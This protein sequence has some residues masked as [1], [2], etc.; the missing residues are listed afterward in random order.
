MSCERER[1]VL[2]CSVIGWNLGGE[3]A[4]SPLS[5]ILVEASDGTRRGLERR[6]EAGFESPTSCSMGLCAMLWWSL[7]VKFAMGEVGRVWR[8]EE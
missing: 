1:A 2:R 3:A 5:F 7:R 6:A 8:G 4:H